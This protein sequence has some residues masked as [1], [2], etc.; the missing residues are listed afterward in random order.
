MA[1]PTSESFRD[2]NNTMFEPDGDIHGTPAPAQNT[3]P[4]VKSTR[5][6][7]ADW[8]D[9]VLN[10]NPAPKQ[11]AD[12]PDNST[13]R[14]FADWAETVLNGKPA[15]KQA[16]DPA[17]DQTGSSTRDKFAQWAEETYNPPKEDKVKQALENLTRACDDVARGYR[18]LYEAQAERVA[19]E[20]QNQPPDL[21]AASNVPDGGEIIG[22]R[23]PH[24]PDP[25]QE[26][27]DIMWRDMAFDPRR[28][29]D[30]WTRMV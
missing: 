13:R 25:I 10:G 30:G 5:E 1:R 4:E 28:D 29:K 7:F 24:Y 23:Q 14:Q 21:P 11:A 17:H 18:E 16:A 2:F 6:K 9:T 8:A 15:P 3:P 20:R 26:L 27:S 12:P 22:E 19:E